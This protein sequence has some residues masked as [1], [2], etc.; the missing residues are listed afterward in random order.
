MTLVLLRLFEILTLVESTVLLSVVLVHC[1]ELQ[2]S[3]LNAAH[4]RCP[5]HNHLVPA[6]A[7]APAEG[8][9]ADSWAEQKAVL[10]LV[11]VLHFPI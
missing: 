1:T 5:C 4:V 6:L 2:C 11:S 7:V 9:C 10:V 8:R 3:L